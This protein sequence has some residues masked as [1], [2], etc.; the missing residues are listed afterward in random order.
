MD[1]KIWLARPEVSH[2]HCVLEYQTADRTFTPKVR[3]IAANFSAPPCLEYCRVPHN[4][5]ALYC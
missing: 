1:S 5:S 2:T 4:Q 3:Q